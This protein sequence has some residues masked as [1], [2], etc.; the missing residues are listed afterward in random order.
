MGNRSVT[1]SSRGRQTFFRE[2]SFRQSPRRIWQVASDRSHGCSGKKFAQLRITVTNKKAAQILSGLTLCAV[3]PQQAFERI[4]NLGG[5][6]AIADGTR[7]GL[8]QA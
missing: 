2:A 6:A 3:S 7:R 4:R 1:E 8:V 5:S